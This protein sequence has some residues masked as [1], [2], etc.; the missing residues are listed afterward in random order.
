M[1]FALV[2]SYLQYVGVMLPYSQCNM[3]F[4]Q[5]VTLRF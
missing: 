1:A 2:G 3:L 5:V 4:D